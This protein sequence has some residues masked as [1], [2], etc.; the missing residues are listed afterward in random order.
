MRRLEYLLLCLE[1]ELLETAHRV[2][3]AI[4]FGLDEVQPGQD[5]TN[6]ERII[7]ELEEVIEVYS[8]IKFQENAE[9]I[10]FP[11][12]ILIL[13]NRQDKRDRLEKYMK[14]SQELGILQ[15]DK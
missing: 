5:K 11:S 15:E 9:Y 1:E 3:K 4:R 8:M 13:G 2:S 14:F 7:E 12:N 6:G 10:P